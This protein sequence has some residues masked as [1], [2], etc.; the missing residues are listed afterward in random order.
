MTKRDLDGVYFRVMRDGSPVNL[1]WTDLDWQDRVDIMCKNRTESWLIRMIELM[2]GVA[3]TVNSA[4]PIARIERIDFPTND[5]LTMEWL[6]TALVRIT[7]DIRMTA[8][9]YDIT[10]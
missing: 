4:V 1:C 9:Q 6:R 5:K 3:E 2:N 7:A 10:A 8:D